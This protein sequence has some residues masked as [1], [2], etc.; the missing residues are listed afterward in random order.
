MSDMIVKLI[1]PAKINLSLTVGKR[2]TNGYH[3]IDTIMQAVSLFDEIDIEASAEPGIIITVSGPFADGVP[4]DERNICFKA[5]AAIC[6]DLSYSPRFHIHIK[7]NIPHGAG[8]GGGSSDAAAVLVGLNAYFAA[9][10]VLNKPL[11]DETLELIG[12]SLGADVPFFIRGGLRRCTGIGMDFSDTDTEFD[13][14]IEN[15]RILIAKGSESVSTAAAYEKL[16]SAGA[17]INRIAP[18]PYFNSFNDFVTNGEIEA[19][20]ALCREY[21]AAAVSLSGSGSAVYAVFGGND[22]KTIQKL[23]YKMREHGFFAEVVEPV[24]HGGKITWAQT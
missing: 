16:D 22:Y 11:S 18:E 6:S 24:A 10:G 7:K 3:E 8:L 20:K 13:R 21:G 23:K 12:C 14:G 15:P 4:T 1:A 5:A 2:L 9:S 17:D 19:I